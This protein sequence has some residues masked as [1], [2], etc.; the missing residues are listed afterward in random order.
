MKSNPIFH[1]C[2]LLFF[3]LSGCVVAFGYAQRPTWGG[4]IALLLY[5]ALSLWTAWELAR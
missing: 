4:A 5:V 2:V 1:W 3:L